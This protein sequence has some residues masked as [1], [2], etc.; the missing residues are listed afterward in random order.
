[1]IYIGHLVF[2]I[3]S[4]I[5]V[6]ITF[7]GIRKRRK[8]FVSI[9]IILFIIFSC[10]MFFYEVNERHSYEQYW[11]YVSPEPKNQ[12]E[13]IVPIA[14]TSNND[15]HDLMNHL[16]IKKG[17]LSYEIVNSSYG[18]GLRVSASEDI[19]IES[20]L[21][22]EKISYLGTF[23]KFPE[24]PHLS[25]KNNSNNENNYFWIYVNIPENSSIHIALVCEGSVRDTSGNL[26]E[27]SWDGKE[28]GSIC[29]IITEPEIEINGWKLI[30][31]SD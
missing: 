2:I 19:E 11:L 30:N 6:F 7:F 9:I 16:N 26:I 25:L 12:F 5:F 28:T 10:T 1:M 17:E 3:I 18:M 24:P 13:I 31:G 14:I 15:I 23:P 20:E 21:Y 8:K 4:I 29:R 27:K 22:D